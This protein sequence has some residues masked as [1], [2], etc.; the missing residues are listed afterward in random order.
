MQKTE[1]L[2]NRIEQYNFE[3]EAG[4]L[5]NCTD[6]QELKKELQP[7]LPQ[8]HVSDQ[9]PCGEVDLC[10]ERGHTM[11]PVYQLSNIDMGGRSSWGKNK[12]SRCGFEED[13]QYDYV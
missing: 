7:L 8:A 9:L 1:Q 12:C 5:I 2:L 3:C 4:N 13:W 11:Y 10:K 6:W